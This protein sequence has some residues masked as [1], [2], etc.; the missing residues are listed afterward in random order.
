MD[1]AI[2]KTFKEKNITS[3][4]LV[5]LLFLS[6]FICAF[7][8]CNSFISYFLESPVQFDQA[9]MQPIE[10]Y[11]FFTISIVSFLVVLFLDP[12]DL[13]D[14]K[15]LVFISIAL[16]WMA[17]EIIRVVTISS[18]PFTVYT[19]QNPFKPGATTSVTY[20]FAAS[21]K[22][23]DIA[24]ELLYCCVIYSLF[25]LF[26]KF[27]LRKAIS[28]SLL[29]LFIAIAILLTLFTFR[30]EEVWKYSAI[31]NA[32]L[33]GK[34]ALP[35]VSSFVMNKNAY[36]F[37][38]WIGMMASMV[39]LEDDKCP[40]LQWAIIIY[41]N[42]MMLFSICKTLFVIQAIF[43][44]I[45]LLYRLIVLIKKHKTKNFIALICFIVLLLGTLL[46]TFLFKGGNIIQTLKKLLGQN[47][48][49]ITMEFRH[50]HWVIAM[51]L[52]DSPFRILFGWSMNGGENLA[53]AFQHVLFPTD[54]VRTTHNGLLD[55]YLRYGLLGALAIFGLIGYLTTYV[56]KT[57]KTKGFDMAFL[58][59][60][61][62]ALT[63][64]YSLNESKF[65]FYRDIPSTMY[66]AVLV[67]PI[68]EIGTRK[69][70]PALEN[71]TFALKQA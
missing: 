61:L 24:D 18:D 3:K 33:N 30:K 25:F 32:V 22:A 51:A 69:P 29:W 12:P 21:D 2:T 59:M 31:F 39:L 65:L 17:T 71:N 45:Y 46:L 43:M 49:G 56:V 52:M 26:P 28:S 8:I 1:N 16:F 47:H 15:L 13:K 5:E 50:R 6:L 64:V 4:S 60:M 57:I 63:F 27:N 44:P 37:I 7:V 54:I 20:G 42:V 48:N 36:A 19:I 55:I 9:H 70:F 41:L 62:F 23:M 11:P 68:L 10:F 66:L 58:F 67:I 53:L 40:L 38:L 34:N 14:K 35:P